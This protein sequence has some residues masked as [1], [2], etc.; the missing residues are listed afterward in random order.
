MGLQN[1]NDQ[2]SECDDAGYTIQLPL[3]SL[4]RYELVERPKQ[5]CQTCGGKNLPR[6]KFPMSASVN[7]FTDPRYEWHECTALNDH[8]RMYVR[9][10]LLD[11]NKVNT[12]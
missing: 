1:F 12:Y 6:P 5:R 7:E 2:C 8:E 3:D 4:D 10:K 9:G 11:D